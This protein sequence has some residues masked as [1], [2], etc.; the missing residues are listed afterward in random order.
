MIVVSWTLIV[1]SAA[2]VAF[3]YAGYP[4]ALVLM[5]RLSPRPVNRADISPPLSLIIAVFNGEKVLR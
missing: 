5:A 3:A 1:V 4:L 2:W